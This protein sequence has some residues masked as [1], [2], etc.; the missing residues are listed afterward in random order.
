MGIPKLSKDETLALY[1]RHAE[2][3]AER[4][5]A[6]EAALAREESQKRNLFFEREELWAALADMRRALER[7]AVLPRGNTAMGIA[8]RALAAAGPAPEEGTA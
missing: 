5:E 4:A 2:A 1:K 6:A 8:R 3:Q 7:I